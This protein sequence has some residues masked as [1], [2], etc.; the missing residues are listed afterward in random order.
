[1]GGLHT[2]VALARL[3]MVSMAA[4]KKGGELVHPMGKVRGEAMWASSVDGI[5]K[6]TPKYGMSAGVIWIW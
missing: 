2:R 3:V 4:Q 5:G 1:M 6:L